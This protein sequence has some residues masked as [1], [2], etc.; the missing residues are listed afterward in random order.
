M[1]LPPHL[2]DDPREQFCLLAYRAREEAEPSSRKGVGLVLLVEEPGRV[3]IL[4]DPEWRK[5]VDSADLEFLEELIADFKQRAKRDPAYLFSQCCSL[6][7]GPLLTQ[8]VGPLRADDSRIR[9]VI[10]RFVAV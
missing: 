9:D 10:R 7:V 2:I 3:R 1:K 4:V 5:A 8:A 6:S